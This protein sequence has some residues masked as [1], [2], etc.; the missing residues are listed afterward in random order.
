MCFETLVTKSSNTAHRSYAW[1]SLKSVS[2]FEQMLN[3]RTKSKRFSLI[4]FIGVIGS[5]QNLDFCPISIVKRLIREH[6]NIL[7]IY[8]EQ[9]FAFSIL[10]INSYTF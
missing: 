8:I 2:L 4:S 1:K 7:L 10:L 6:L 9:L 3:Q 5:A